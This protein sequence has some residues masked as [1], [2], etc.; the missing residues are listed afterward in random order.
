MT[1]K[2][3]KLT[4]QEAKVPGGADV[5]FDGMP[6]STLRLWGGLSAVFTAALF[7]YFTYFPDHPKPVTKEAFFRFMPAVLAIA[8]TAL[9]ISEFPGIAAG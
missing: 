5:V 2:K 3:H 4:W 1:D 6:P 9:A 8:G 7:V